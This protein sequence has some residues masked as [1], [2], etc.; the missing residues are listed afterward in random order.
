M[1]AP[2]VTAPP[3]YDP[4][5]VDWDAYRYAE[6]QWLRDGGDLLH[7]AEGVQRY[8]DEH[9]DYASDKRRA[10][11]WDDLIARQREW[12]TRKPRPEQYPA[13]R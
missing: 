4:Q 11:R 13:D 3:T 12:R 2:D 1:N 5:T 9:P 10:E 8:F 7:I 6:V